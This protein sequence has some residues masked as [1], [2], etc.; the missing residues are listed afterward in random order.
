M[1]QTA[2]QLA[3]SKQLAKMIIIAALIIIVIGAVIYRSPAV[4]PFALGVIATSGLNIMKV[5]MLERTVERVLDMDDQQ[6]GKNTVRLQY[7]LRYFLTGVVLVAI[8][9]IQSYTTPPPFYS[10]RDWYI[11]VWSIL[12]PNAPEALLAAPLI[13]IW[14]AIFG[15]FT[16]QISIIMLRI[17]KPEK[18]GTNFIKY[19]DDDEDVDDEPDF[20][21]EDKADL[22]TLKETTSKEL[23]DNNVDQ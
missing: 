14:G 17:I 1:N 13:S 7:L 6:A 3:T 9:M 22:E 2:Q 16:L 8:G 10:S 12:F 23:D 21:D 4:I 11:G 20:E 15:L 18:D 5:R 19:E